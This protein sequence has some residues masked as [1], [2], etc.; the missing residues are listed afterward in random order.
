M[1][2]NGDDFEVRTSKN[3]IRRQLESFE[4]VVSSFSG[5]LLDLVCL[6]AESCAKVFVIHPEISALFGS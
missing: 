4:V 2:R 1:G 6:Y 3:D 5:R